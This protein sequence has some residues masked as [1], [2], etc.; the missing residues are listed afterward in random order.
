METGIIIPSGPVPP[1]DKNL[2][3]DTMSEF[4]R[5]VGE[6]LIDPTTNLPSLR[7]PAK[8][9]RKDIQKSKKSTTSKTSTALDPDDELLQHALENEDLDDEAMD[10]TPAED[11]NTKPFRLEDSILADEPTID[12]GLGSALKLAMQK[13]LLLFY[14]NYYINSLFVCVL[15]GYID[16]E[17]SRQN[18]RF[19]SDISAKN[20]TV[21]EKSS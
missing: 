17:K 14:Q 7:T 11:V 8:L 6:S 16:Q 13:G 12:R 20:Y 10:D 3:L 21:E 4:C 2:V 5:N 9:R 15:I 18:A 19:V 1:D